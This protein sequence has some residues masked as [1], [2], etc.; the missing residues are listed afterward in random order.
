[1]LL[2]EY[3]AF[4]RKISF[5]NVKH[6]KMTGKVEQG[7]AVTDWHSC[8]SFNISTIHAYFWFIFVSSLTY[9]QHG[10]SSVKI[11]EQLQQ[12]FPIITALEHST[13][14]NSREHIGLIWYLLVIVS[15]R[16]NSM[17]CR[18][19]FCFFTPSIVQRAWSILLSAT[20]IF[21]PHLLIII[22]ITYCFRPIS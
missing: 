2:S 4:L 16:N 1:M 14:C 6:E 12:P 22:K 9:V 21:I 18:D 11:C 3:G 15:I 10:D 8:R 5:L 17:A 7:K 13:T 20:Y 19:A